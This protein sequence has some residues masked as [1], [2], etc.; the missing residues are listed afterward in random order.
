[1]NETRPKTMDCTLGSMS[2]WAGLDYEVRP[3]LPCF[4]KRCWSR[5]VSTLCK[6]N[7]F[8]CQELFILWGIS[9]TTWMIVG[10]LGTGV[11]ETGLIISRR[12]SPAYYAVDTLS[13]NENICF[14]IAPNA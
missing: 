9:K 7:T 8:F 12:K 4:L 1:V 14:K 11:G 6:F 2:P 5:Y 10:G 13:E 3:V